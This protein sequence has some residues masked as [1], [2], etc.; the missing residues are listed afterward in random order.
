MKKH[1]V[2]FLHSALGTS[3][4]LRPLMDLIADHG[5]TVL[6]F[7]FAGHGKKGAFPS[8]FRIDLFAKELDTYLKTHK[9]QDISVFGHSMGGYVALYHAT[10]YEDSPFQR[11]FTYGTKFNWGPETVAKELPS[12]NPTDLAQ[13]FPDHAR[14]LEAKHGERW[15]Q[16]ML[17]TAHMIQHLEK[18][19]GLTRAD[20]VDLMIPVVLMLGDQD[21]M[22]TSEETQTTRSWL[23]HASVKTISHSK[24]DLERANLKEISQVLLEALD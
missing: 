9:L 2:L 5:H 8:E 24:H 21:R 13:R 10:N 6:T 3:Q 14:A 22:V 19:D 16:L 7:D 23:H 20:L 18:L 11:I 4:D 15:K 17:S 12:L 1:T